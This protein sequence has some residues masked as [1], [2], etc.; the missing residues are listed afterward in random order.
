MSSSSNGGKKPAAGGGRGGPTIRTLSDLNSGPA[1][2]PGAGGGGS[3]SDDD[4]PQEYY[5][6]G[7][8]RYISAP[9]VGQCFLID[10]AGICLRSCVRASGS[11]P[12]SFVI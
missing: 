8:K 4:E 5:T 7:E 6:G 2:F 3:G 11:P 9:L 1:G 10:S 12:P